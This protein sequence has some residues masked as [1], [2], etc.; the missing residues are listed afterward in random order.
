MQ[1]NNVCDFWHRLPP[2]SPLW[3]A[4]LQSAV[5]ACI[6]NTVAQSL[7]AY[8]EN[9]T[10]ATTFS[11]ITLLRF[12]ALDLITA[13]PNYKWQEVLERTFPARPTSIK[14]KYSRSM[15][16]EAVPLEER[17]ANRDIEAGAQKSDESSSDDV[18]PQRSRPQPR[19][20]RSSPLKGKRSWRNTFAKWFID[21]ITLGAVLNTLAFLIIMGA[22]KGQG[23]SK[24]G[25][26]IRHETIGI[27]LNGYKIWPIANF[28]A[29]TLVPW[30][31]KIVWFAF[32]GLC[33]NV[34]LSLVAIRI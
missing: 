28:I 5:I 27:I 15:E 16:Y 13:P 32:V 9:Q 3:T 31:K 34:Y 22:L 25:Y 7:H 23:V 18:R 30:E 8:Q 24:I 19:R 4:V 11:I 12:L 26:N 2:I 20:I 14:H 21:C 33:W 10:F 1:S 6:S 29:H 17:A